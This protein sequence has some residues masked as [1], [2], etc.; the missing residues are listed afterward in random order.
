MSEIP[1]NGKSIPLTQALENSLA[2]QIL[3]DDKV[4]HL[5]ALQKAQISPPQEP[6]VVAGRQRNKVNALATWGAAACLLLAVVL[7]F[8]QWYVRD[9]SDLIAQEVVK[10][11]IKLKPLEV[12]G[13]DL[14][15]VSEYFTELDFWISEPSDTVA[16][17]AG[18]ALLGGRYCSIRG[19]TA[20][21][22][23]YQ[24]ASPVNGSNTIKQSANL[25]TL[26]QAPFNRQVHGRI[27][28]ISHGA[29]VVEYNGFHVS[30]WREHGVLFVFVRGA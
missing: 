29:K 28:L 14:T 25:G 9:Y 26:Y 10:N 2:K 16:A 12:T 1:N 22:L 15:A 21:Q 27:P 13:T 19:V 23:R 17:I 20:A 18:K 3:S 24:L 7:G 4:A 8:N 11:H 5:L 30:L 6:T